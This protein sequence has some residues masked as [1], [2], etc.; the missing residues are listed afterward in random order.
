MKKAIMLPYCIVE[1]I[2]SKSVAIAP[3]AWLSYEEDVCAWPPSNTNIQS[4]VKNIY[5]PGTD[6]NQFTV[7]VLGKAGNKLC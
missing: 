1:F 2:D 5:K 3:T 6:W 7:R 4:A